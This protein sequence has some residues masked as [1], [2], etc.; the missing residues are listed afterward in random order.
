MDHGTEMEWWRT[1]R[2]HWDNQNASVWIPN[3][4]ASA[5]LKPG[6]S[7]KWTNDDSFMLVKWRDRRDVYIIATNDDGVMLVKWRNRRDVY[8]IA[9]NDD[10]VMLVKWRN[11]RDVYMIATNDDGVML[12]KWRDRRDV[13]MIAT[14][15]EGLDVV[16]Q[17]CQEIQLPDGWCRQDGPASVVL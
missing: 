4:Q 16:R 9:T 11:R 14:N 8:M 17:V 5:K 7:I 15:D 13:Y 2:Q 3:K 12:F 6:E 1:F 10:G